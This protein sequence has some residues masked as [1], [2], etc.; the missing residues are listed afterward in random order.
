MDSCIVG[1]IQTY[2]FEPEL[3][4]KEEEEELHQNQNGQF[5]F[6]DIKPRP[7]VLQDGF[8]GI[9]SLLDCRTITEI[10]MKSAEVY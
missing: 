2:M 10:L 5:S 8:L 6:S 7:L 9:S 3:D 1:I 4:S